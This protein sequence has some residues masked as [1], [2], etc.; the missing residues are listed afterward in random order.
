M[1]PN[2]LAK[3]FLDCYYKA[4]SSNR[5]DLLG[6]YTENSCMS[7]NGEHCKGLKAIKE[8]IEGLGFGSVSLEN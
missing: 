3:Q 6:F 5:A 7:Y 2:D 4:Q 1:N 8:K